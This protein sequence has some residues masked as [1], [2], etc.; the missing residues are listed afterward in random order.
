MFIFFC[1]KLG[2]LSFSSISRLVI[3]LF[4][5]VTMLGSNSQLNGQAFY[6]TFGKNR[7]QFHGFTWSFYESKNFVVYFYQGGQQYG[8]YSVQTAENNLPNIQTKLE[9][10]LD[11]KIEI[12]VY[13]NIS[14]LNQ[15]NIGNEYENL[16]ANSAGRTKVVSNKVFVYFNGD[17]GHLEKQIREGIAR[18]YVANMLYGDNVQEV[19][20][21]AFLLNLPHW[22]KEGLIAYLGQGWSADLD[23]RLRDLILH[24]GFKNFNRMTKEE[25]IFAGHAF[26]YY[27]SQNYNKSAVPNLLYL[28]RINRSLES[29]FIYVIGQTLQ[30]TIDEWMEYNNTIYALDENKRAVI[31]D[32]A[33]VVTNKKTN[34]QITEMALSREGN[35]LAYVSN[36]S[37]RF[38][39]HLKNLET[40]DSQVIVKG[41]IATFEMPVNTNYPLLAWSKNK[42]KLAIVYQKRDQLY[43]M[44]YWADKD[45]KTI[46]AITKFQQVLAIDFTD[47]DKKLIF[48]GV[49]RGQVD[50]FTY[51]MPNTKV[52]QITNDFFDDLQPAFYKDEQR[53][54]ILFSS[55]RLN[56]TLRTQKQDTI[57]PTGN[58]DVF[59]YDLDKQ[60]S[61][62]TRLYSSPNANEWQIQQLKEGKIGLLS[63][64][65]GIFNYYTGTLENI[66]SHRDKVVYFKDSTT[67]TNPG[68]NLKVDS[69]RKAGEIVDIKT[70][71]VFKPTLQ[72]QPVSNLSRNLSQLA[73][74]SSNGKSLVLSRYNNIDY[75][76][77]LSSKAKI[78]PLKNT[79]YKQQFINQK[80]YESTVIDQPV[81]PFTKSNKP[82]KSSNTNEED[83]DGFEIIMEEIGADD[84]ENEVDSDA[85]FLDS[86]FSKADRPKRGKKKRDKKNKK[87]EEPEIVIQIENI[88]DDEDAPVFISTKVRPYVPKFSLEKITTQLDNSLMF[89]PYLLPNDTDLNG[90]FRYSV[91][92]L[93]EDHRII[94]GFRFPLS[95]SGLEWLLEY[96][97]YKKRF[98]KKI[99]YYRKGEV[100]QALSA[101]NQLIDVRRR[102]SFLETALIY[103]LDY[104]QSIRAYVG[105]RNEKNN[106]LS[107]ELSTLNAPDFINNWA[108]TKLE[109]VYDNTR[110]LGLNIKAGTRYKIFTE[111]YQPFDGVLNDREVQFNIPKNNLLGTFGIDARHYEPLFRKVIIAG[112]F[113]G[114]TSFGN[115]RILYVLGGVENW[116]NRQVDNTTPVN[117]NYN[118]VFTNQTNHLRGFKN[119]ARN[120]NNVMI[121]NT[122]LRIPVM[123]T[124]F[125]RTFKSDILNSFQ[126]VPF[127]DFGTAWIGSNPFQPD[128]T[129]VQNTFPMVDPVNQG[130]VTTPV[131]VTVNYFRNPFIGGY[132]LG[133]RTKL[134]GYFLKFDIA[135]GLDNGQGSDLIRYL[136]F[137]Y[138]F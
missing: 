101:D 83:D 64:Q 86:G 22:F 121:L 46:K 20:Q 38:K 33:A 125:N 36:K 59:F 24:K 82:A 122:E 91:S 75:I 98:D 106:I 124:L 55:N 72:L 134:L 92:D 1:K 135:R 81:D 137:G 105:W 117:T 71:K 104:A 123:T 79:N 39:V 61:I 13:H 11:K 84:K 113:Y 54:G 48:S 90:L 136:S 40:D 45:E 41:G 107:T 47:D 129:F 32:S 29:A 68:K 102:T 96:Q 114:A 3:V 74:S 56:D 119:N 76:F 66:L 110:E 35:Y 44:N 15:T 108:Y 37:G 43:L 111:L 63:D 6:T 94:G 23:S 65:N 100:T 89:T 9:Y 78:S 19:L 118:Y 127:F 16:E 5:I 103:P 87:N 109:Y 50:L 115:N 49:R 28:A 2:V 130:P 85:Y 126:L 17:H 52:V 4:T 80:P 138:D 93:M 132:G 26:W 8:E 31:P 57:L 67:V 112:R 88:D 77:E 131:L 133:F 95:F 10:F 120:G 51:N 73:V 7:V 128:V 42:N 62:A 70:K 53:R 18:V 34:L 14:D 12:M 25:S 58:Y 116:I 60:Q 21:N 97:N 99:T 69:L 30:N 27:L